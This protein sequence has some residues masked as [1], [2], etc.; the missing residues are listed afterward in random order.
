M[1]RS[2]GIGPIR[3]FFRVTLGQA[4]SAIIGG[5]LLVCLVMLAEYGA[6]EILGYRTFT[7]EIFAEFQTAFNLPAASALSLVLVAVSLLVVGADL[8]LRGRGQV[9][10][11]AGQAQRRTPPVR[12]GHATIPVLLGFVGLVGLALGVPV[13]SSIYWMLARTPPALTGVPLL[14]AA[15]HTAMYA[16]AAAAIATVAAIPLAVLSVRHPGRS[17]HLLERSTL[18]VL[19]MPGLVT[20]LALSYFVER[21]AG[22]FLYQ[23][24][25]L[26]V[27][28]YSIL[29]YPLALVAVRA[30]V[31][32]APA[33][34]DDVARSL[35]RGPVAVLLRVTLPLI[36][37]GLAAGFSLVF[38]SAVT[39][40]T[41]TLILVPTGVQTLATQFWAYQQNLSYGQAAPFA[42]LIMGIAAVP[43][44][45]LGRWFDRLPAAASDRSDQVFP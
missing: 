33:R 42:L 32:R 14:T 40:L 35:G 39:E 23:S 43:S 38:L 21:Y 25:T 15:V 44:V 34:L 16:A 17:I 5:A 28:A 22:G 3:T 31:A 1:S 10:R 36:A 13:G 12:L 11:T 24:A 30:S 27:L 9:V 41:A 26:L 6:F 2:L 19:G 18:L 37:P 20:A 29:F 7:T 8:R 4:R 45:V